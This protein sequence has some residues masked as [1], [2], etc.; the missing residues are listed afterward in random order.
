MLSLAIAPDGKSL[1]SGVAREVRLYDLSAAD[2]KAPPRVLATH[3]GDVTSVAFTPDGGALVSASHDH[4]LQFTRLATSKVE[5]RAPGSFEQVN[6]VA[7]SN[8]RALL[9]TGSSDGRFAR[10]LLPADSKH[11]GPGAVRLWDAHTGRMLRRLG[12]PAE[13]VMAVA[14][15]PD[16]RRIA[17]GGGTANG[18]GAVHVWDAANG[19]LLWSASD[20]EREVL[21]IAFAHDGSSVA[22]GA[23]DGSVK[24]R[25]AATGTV[26]LTLPDH[27]AGATSIAFSP[28]GARLFA[29]QGQGGARVWEL[30]R[31]SD[32]GGAARL[33]RTCDAPVSPA[34]TYTIDR[35]MNTVALTR[36]GATLAVCP[37]STNDEFVGPLRL[38]DARTCALLRDF[39]P[40]NIHGRPM[41]LSP[42][43]AIVATGGKSIKLWDTRTGK[44]LRE[45]NGYLKRTQ[46]IAFSADGKLIVE[47]GSY[48]TTN[49]WDVATGRHLA[50]LF[51]F[52]DPQTGAATDHWL[53][54]TPDGDYDGSAGVERFLAWRVGDELQTAQSL[55]PQLHRLD[56]V[57]AALGSLK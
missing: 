42:D 31:G 38:F 52:P 43:G 18:K 40:E 48:G 49:L 29:G 17:A 23:S 34:S 24:V 47:G 53:A 50:T 57:A 19:T 2:V 25:D 22:S 26:A 12:D 6:S 20:H 41:A 44:P 35:L 54:T 46:S 56:R 21:A 15:S 51:T 45:L 13:Q 11:I 27:A 33:L 37:S 36:D 32:G 28:D 1:A 39:T 7:L 10:G 14:I 8:D 30:R 3:D 4:A 9:V 5:W 16:G 55:A